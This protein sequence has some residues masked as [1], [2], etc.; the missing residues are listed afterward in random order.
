MEPPSVAD[1]LKERGNEAFK[2]G[3]FDAAIVL[4]DKALEL[5]PGSSILHANRAA[6]WM[7]KGLF[8]EGLADA[9][10]SLELQRNFAKGW[11]RKGTC[12]LRLG[13][14]NEATSAWLEGRTVV[15]AHPTDHVVML[16]SHLHEMLTHHFADKPDASP[17]VAATADASLSPAVTVAASDEP[18]Q[19][20]AQLMCVQCHAFLHRPVTL[21]CGCS[22]CQSCAPVVLTQAPY[23]VCPGRCCAHPP[24]YLRTHPMGSASQLKVCVALSGLLESCYPNETKLAAVRVAAR[25]AAQSRQDAAC[26]SALAEG[27]AQC[28]AETAL[29]DIRVMK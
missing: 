26:L 25:T 3:R 12:L 23:P 20:F 24:D 17:A 4:Y 7:G 10:T 18:V 2:Q 29:Y 14:V 9:N 22:C 15:P 1:R 8:S 5:Q 6:A 11:S 16:T 19:L 27:L 13:R 28:P 21:S